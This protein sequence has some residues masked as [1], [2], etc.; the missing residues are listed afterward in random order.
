M[1]E[2]SLQQSGKESYV[3]KDNA[4]HVSDANKLY[5]VRIYDKH[6]QLQRTI[7]PKELKAKANQD[8]KRGHHWNKKKAK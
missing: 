7:S 5:E 6:G 8:L 1:R 4:Y 3:C 2:H